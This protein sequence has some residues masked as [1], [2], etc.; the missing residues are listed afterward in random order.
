MYYNDFP[1]VVFTMFESETDAH[2][3]RKLYRVRDINKC[4][5]NSVGI[6]RRQQTL[7]VS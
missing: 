6:G 2:T 5:N 3:N 1:N 7:R 4:R